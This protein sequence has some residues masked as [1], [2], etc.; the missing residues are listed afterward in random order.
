MSHD[1]GLRGCMRREPCCCLCGELKLYEVAGIIQG[2]VEDSGSHA[3][4]AVG[5][6]Q[7]AFLFP[8]AGVAHAPEGHGQGVG[9]EAG[10][11]A[12]FCP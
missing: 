7:Y 4:E 5:R 6:E 11:L 10:R 1:L 8:C 3:S 9:V 12:V 2:L